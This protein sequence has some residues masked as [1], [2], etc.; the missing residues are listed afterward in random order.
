MK[1][2]FSQVVDILEKERQSQD[3][4]W[5]SLD[6]KHQTVAGYLL[7]L[8][9]EL[10]EAKQGWMKNIDGKHSSLSEIVQIAA[11]AIACIQQHGNSGNPP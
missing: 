10:N 1:L 5:G 8:E 11:V 2:S 4:K 9:S 7:V 3:L 6:E